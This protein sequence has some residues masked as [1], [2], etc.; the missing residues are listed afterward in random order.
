[1][2]KDNTRFPVETIKLLTGTTVGYGSKDHSI[3]PFYAIAACF[4]G[5]GLPVRLANNRYEQFQLGM[6]RHSIE[7]DVTI[8]A[9]RKSGA[10][11]ILKGFYNLNGG[12][13]RQF[14]LLGRAG[15]RN[16][17]A[18][19][20]LFPEIRSCGHRACNA[21]SGGRVHARLRHHSGNEHHRADG[22]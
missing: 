12:G 7:M 22:R 9:D 13:P 6:K 18:I 14:F 3:F 8:V 15:S 17:R 21:C 11:E 5:G 10:F 2:V 4:Y 1:M 19:R 20:L 16:R